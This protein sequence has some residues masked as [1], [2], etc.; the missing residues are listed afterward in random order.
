MTYNIQVTKATASKINKVDFDDIPFGKVYSD[1]MFLAEYDNGHWHDFKIVPFQN[2]L[3]SPASSVLHYGQAIFEGLKAF[4]NDDGE[5]QM[6]RPEENVARMNRSAKRMAMPEIP[7]DLFM[8]AMEKLIQ[9][10][11][12]WIP[13]KDGSSLYIRPFMIANEP[14][15][16]V[17]PATHFRFCII[18]APVGAYY[19]HPVKV[20]VAQKYVRAVV[21][22]VGAAKTAGNYGRTL[23]PV[24]EAK[25]SGYDQILW[26]RAPEF[27]IAQE[28]G[29]MNVFFVIGDT[30]ITP[31]LDGAILEGVTRDTCITILKSKGFQV[32]ER[33]I[34]LNEVLE[35]YKNRVLHDAFGTGT[36]ATVSFISEINYKGEIMNLPDPSARKISQMLKT[37]LSDIKRSR[38]EDKFGWNHKVRIPEAG[39]V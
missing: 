16:G 9:I 34:S 21:G 4:M 26:T 25:E 39:L 28:I 38:I 5:A 32:E 30:V 22:G 24:L 14:Y 19:S 37:T 1:H 8:Q 27:E 29:T 2:L 33:D 10:D 12:D 35:A 17:K 11:C 15:I 31:M 36:A 23:Q 7:A 18:T 13:R 20:L 3:M 6:F